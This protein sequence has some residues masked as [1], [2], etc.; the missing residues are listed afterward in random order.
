MIRKAQSLFIYT[1]ITKPWR[2]FNVKH[3]NLS[4]FHA[5]QRLPTDLSANRR[6][7]LMIFKV[8]ERISYDCHS[9]QSSI[10]FIYGNVI[11]VCI[12]CTYSYQYSIRN[13][14]Y[15]YQKPNQRATKVFSWAYK[16]DAFQSFIH[17]GRINAWNA[18]VVLTW[19]NRSN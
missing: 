15:R 9:L 19:K 17:K 10:R 4:Q 2:T 14:A 18:N 7:F 5:F 11:T 12:R 16:L 6:T 13:S 1:V 3:L 8:M